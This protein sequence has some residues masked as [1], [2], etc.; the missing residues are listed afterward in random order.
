MCFGIFKSFFGEVG[1]LNAKTQKNHTSMAVLGFLV[2]LPSG[3]VIVNAL[4]EAGI[5]IR[6]FSN[7][8]VT[9]VNFVSGTKVQKQRK[10]RSM[11]AGNEWHIQKENL[12]RIC[13]LGRS[14]LVIDQGVFLFVA[15]AS[16]ASA[17]EKIDLVFFFIFL[18]S[19]HLSFGSPSRM[20]FV[21]PRCLAVSMVQ[22]AA[23][24]S[25]LRIYCIGS[26]L[27]KEQRKMNRK[28]MKRTK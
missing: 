28:E 22:G 11:V 3:A 25:L 13:V 7:L 23:S 6:P 14:V 16:S 20:F 26:C 17:L 19:F 10:S 9:L 5:S 15:V 24:S 12:T 21:F 2:L 18:I 27:K 8:L 4:E 1:E